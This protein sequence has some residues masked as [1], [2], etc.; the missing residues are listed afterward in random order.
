M[1]DEHATRD[2]APSMRAVDLALPRPRPERLP[3]AGE[4]VRV[5]PLDPARHGPDL[6]RLGHDGSPA[7]EQSWA[8]LPYGPFASESAHRSWLESQAASSDP[9]FFA[10]VD[11]EER[12]VGV[13]TLMSIVPAH[14]SIEIGHIWL[15]PGLQRTP[16]AR[17]EASLA[18]LHFHS[19]RR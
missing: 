1:S 8:Y 17:R 2:R 13:A 11:R 18:A 15:S 14:G 6:F 9:L 16:A 10:I 12:A 7:A 19:R 4:R 5:E 3:L